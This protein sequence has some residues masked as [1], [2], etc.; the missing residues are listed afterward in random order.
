MLECLGGT[1]AARAGGGAVVVSTG[2]GAEVAFPDLIGWRRPAKNLSR[3]M[4]G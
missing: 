4:N 1:L 2:V 3:P